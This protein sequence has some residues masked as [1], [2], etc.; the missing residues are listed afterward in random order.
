MATKTSSKTKK[1]NRKSSKKGRIGRWLLIIFLLL[2]IPAGI[3]IARFLQ[4]NKKNVAVYLT[5][6]EY[7]AL[8]RLAEREGRSR[9]AQLLMALREQGREED[10]WQSLDDREFQDRLLAE[11]HAAKGD[12]VTV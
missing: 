3:G 8:S 12:L 10:L 4:K 5:P 1:S 7:Q 2:A 11:M 9:G 6:G